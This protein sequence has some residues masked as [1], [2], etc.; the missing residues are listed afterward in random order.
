M[1][2]NFQVN[3]MYLNTEDGGLMNKSGLMT[4]KCSKRLRDYVKIYPYCLMYIL[5]SEN[6]YRHSSQMN[7]AAGL[8][9]HVFIGHAIKATPSNSIE[10]AQCL[11]IPVRR[12]APDH[13]CVEAAFFIAF[14]AVICQS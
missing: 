12:F 5:K 1:M 2:N 10:T 4:Q 13:C 11:L 6:A 14:G 8:S 9:R 7:D 3:T